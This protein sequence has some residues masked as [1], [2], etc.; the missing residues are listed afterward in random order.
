MFGADFKS[1]IRCGFERCRA[2][3]CRCPVAPMDWKQ[4]SFQP[5]RTRLSARPTS[6][7]LSDTGAGMVCFAG[8]V[9]Q[10][11]GFLGPPSQDRL[12]LR[13]SQREG[14]ASLRLAGEA[15]A[16][17][18]ILFGEQA[19]AVGAAALPR[20]ALGR[21]RTLEN[22]RS[23]ATGTGGNSST[24][25][26]VGG[27]GTASPRWVTGMPAAAETAMPAVTEPTEDGFGRS[28][29]SSMHRSRPGCHRASRGRVAGY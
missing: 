2:R 24:G 10:D 18:K 8:L 9:P 6:R 21:E 7:V 14:R 11:M 17:S 16:A 20:R 27:G 13:Q 3:L 22:A 23:G 28:P 12:R 29:R 15:H 5:G 26:G 19:H 1:G 25:G 4:R